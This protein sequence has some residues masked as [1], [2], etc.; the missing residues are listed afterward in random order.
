MS[1]AS[2]EVVERSVDQ[3]WTPRLARQFCPVSSFFLAN[4]HRL[5]PHDNAEG[6]N[7]SEAM[8]LIH[9]FDHKWDARAP[10]PT[11]N[12]IARRMGISD[13]QVRSILKRLE[14]LGYVR[15]DP[16]PNGGPNRYHMDG[17][18]SALEKMMDEDTERAA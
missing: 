12:T 15:R 1:V 7:S 6:L 13:R 3:R 18:I 14:D 10:W 16:F 11:V 8:V 9:I 2:S 17:L 4:Y 5:R